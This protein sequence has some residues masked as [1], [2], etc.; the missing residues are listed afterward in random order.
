MGRGEIGGGSLT[1]GRG[2]DG[3]LGNVG[4]D[5]ADRDQRGDGVVEVLEPGTVG[6]LETQLVD[7]VVGDDRDILRVLLA[8]ADLK[9]RD[10]ILFGQIGQEHEGG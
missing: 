4:S 1:N 3:A 9:E 6:V 10:Q 8:S 7:D 5:A 2:V